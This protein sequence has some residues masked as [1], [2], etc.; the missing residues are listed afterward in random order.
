MAISLAGITAGL[1]GG[2]VMSGIM[3]IGRRAGFL[4]PTLND[5]RKP[6]LTGH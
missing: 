6:G 3:V 5:M 4:H 1:I 2:S